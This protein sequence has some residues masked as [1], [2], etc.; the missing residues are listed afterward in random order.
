MRLRQLSEHG[1]LS[2]GVDAAGTEQAGY[3][4]TAK[5]EALVP[6][7]AA[8]TAWGDRWEP[9]PGGPP[10]RLQHADCGTTA[11]AVTCTRCG[12]PVT[13]RTLTV[14]AGP[15]GRIGPGTARIGTR[16][17]ATASSSAASP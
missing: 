5:G 9:S 16:L 6:I 2:K 13:A 11:V 1:I 15:G 14:Q 3:R 4:L 17:R 10:M 8:L 12:E 7:L